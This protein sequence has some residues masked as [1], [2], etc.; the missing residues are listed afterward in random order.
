ML[1][2][3]LIGTF[4]DNTPSDIN[5]PIHPT[6]RFVILEVGVDLLLPNNT[7]SVG[8]AGVEFRMKS[9]IHHST[10]PPCADC[11]ST[12]IS[13]PSQSLTCLFNRKH[14]RFIQTMKSCNS[15]PTIATNGIKEA[16]GYQSRRREFPEP[17]RLITQN[18][19]MDTR[20][21]RE[22]DIKRTG[23]CQ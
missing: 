22:N 5:I 14:D 9:H 4:W 6:Q 19:A 10:A 16:W 17:H 8:L 3:D 15:K 2:P 12:L 21:Q 18:N 1:Y 7:A 11:W 23:C 20:D 13:L